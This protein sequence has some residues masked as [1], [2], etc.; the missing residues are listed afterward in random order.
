MNSPYL[1][2]P[3]PSI[4]RAAG[5]VFR[6]IAQHPEWSRLFA[7]GKMLG[8]LVYYREPLRYLVAYSGV[9]N[10]LS[11]PDQYFVPPIYDLQNPADFYLQKDQEISELN[12]RIA[13][14]MVET[15]TCRE[16]SRRQS[17]ESQIKQQRQLRKQL[18]I[19]LQNE[20]F[21]HFDVINPK[22]KY[23]NVVDI[24]ADSRHALPPGGTGECAGPRLLQ[25]AL[26]HGVVPLEMAEFWYGASPRSTFRAHRQFYPACIEKCSPLI[27]YMTQ[28]LGIDSAPEAET[29]Q[30]IT[31]LPIVWEDDTIVIVSKPAGVLSVPG[32]VEGDS[33]EAYLHRRYPEVKGPMLV[34][35]LDQ[36]TSGLLLAAKDAR[37]H[38]TLQEAFTSRSVHKQ[39]L[40]WLDSQLPS[41]C[42]I[43][44]LPICPNPDDRPRQTV[45]LRFGKPAV[46]HYEVLERR[47]DRTLVRFSPLTG[48]TH[49][50]RLHAASHFGLGHPIVGDRIYGGSASERL[51]LHAARLTFTHPTTAEVISV[52]ASAG[53]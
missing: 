47:A 44:C 19:A 50:L 1:Y 11:D 31:D 6:H 51:M 41:D 25:F 40:A 30:P 9:I 14:L 39:Y 20:I 2:R 26:E 38:R 45:D 53:M 29:P 48:R 12:L 22:G 37:T 3:Q 35:R 36:S 24:F 15:E 34:H 13:S 17:L 4:L 21:R 43:I 28:G 42:G 16:P 10:G 33:V 23:R 7:Q 46:T 5:D 18:S 27:T 32:K 8:I 52:E 49:Q